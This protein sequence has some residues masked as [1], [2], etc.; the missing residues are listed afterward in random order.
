M[1][2]TAFLSILNGVIFLFT[3][4]LGMLIFGNATD[5]VGVMNMRFF[6]ACAAGFGVVLWTLRGITSP[7]VQKGVSLGSLVTL[8]L[9]VIV[10]LHGAITGNIHF[11]GFISV[12]IDL[13]LSIGFGYFFVTLYRKS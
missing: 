5:L 11:L 2:I 7:A 13:L 12:G 9:S 10:G 1:S 3:P 6:G 4:R 8:G